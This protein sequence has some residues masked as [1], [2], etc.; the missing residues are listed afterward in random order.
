MPSEK[1]RPGTGRSQTMKTSRLPAARWKWEP[2]RHSD[3]PL[4]TADSS[5]PA[6]PRPGGAASALS[7]KVSGRARG[8]G[9]GSSPAPARAGVQP[10]SLP[11]GQENVE[12]GPHRA[13]HRFPAPP[14]GAVSQPTAPARPA[15]TGPDLH[16]AHPGAATAARS[17]C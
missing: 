6:Q 15:C 4:S 5:R 10:H 9:G 13:R 12:A 2:F 8:G 3:G 1:P 11:D 14:D 16:G 7:G 17:L